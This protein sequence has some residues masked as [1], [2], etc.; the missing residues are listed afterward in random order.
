MPQGSGDVTVIIW[1]RERRSSTER[2]SFQGAGGPHMEAQ[3]PTV[4]ETVCHPVG[5]FPAL[6]HL[7]AVLEAHW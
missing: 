6:N 7:Q 5:Q 3:R 1:Q 2:E 4:Q